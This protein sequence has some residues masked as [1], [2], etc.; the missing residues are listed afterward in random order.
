MYPSIFE[1]NK[2]I[3]PFERSTLQ[4]MSV[5]V[6]D[7]EKEKINRFPYHSK[8]HSTLKEKKFVTLYAEDLH[9]LISR[10]GWLVTHIYAH[11]TFKQSKFKKRFCNNKSKV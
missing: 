7:E 9:F 6:R 8:T 5:I 11:Y 3:D 4:L 10:A 1:K 2:K